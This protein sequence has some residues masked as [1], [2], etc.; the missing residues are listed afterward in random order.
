M[1]QTERILFDYTEE[2]K[3][4][5]DYALECELRA[6]SE[7]RSTAR[8]AIEQAETQSERNLHSHDLY[9][10]CTYIGII[11]AEMKRRFIP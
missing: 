7:A 5:D 4:L 9:L 11:A 6:Q 1:T 8:W 2:V 3:R 10:C